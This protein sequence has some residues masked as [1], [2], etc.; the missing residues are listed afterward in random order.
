MAV[1]LVLS[2][3]CLVAITASFA[4][5]DVTGTRVGGSLRVTQCRTTAD[6]VHDRMHTRPEPQL[7]TSEL[8]LKWGGRG[9]RKT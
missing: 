6:R 4:V 5:M 3:R 9:S 1:N 8:L 2:G 7:E